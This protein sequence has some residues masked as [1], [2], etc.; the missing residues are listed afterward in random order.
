M[1]LAKPMKP[2]KSLLPAEVN[3]WLHEHIPYR[4][5]GASPLTPHLAKWDITQNHLVLPTGLKGVAVNYS[6][7]QGQRAALRWLI[8]FV[9][10]RRGRDGKPAPSQA[11]LE[12]DPTDVGIWLFPNGYNMLDT[13]PAAREL[14]DMW[15]GCSQAISHPTTATNHPSVLTPE[16]VSA[17]GKV[18]DYLETGIYQTYNLPAL[19]HEYAR[20][21]HAGMSGLPPLPIHRRQGLL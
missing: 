19:I 1:F 14:A 9:G 17:F 11:A 12:S 10:I 16:V 8:E 18:V 2:R 15:K 7:L 13:H 5:V 20:L 3:A 4:L 21:R 6:L